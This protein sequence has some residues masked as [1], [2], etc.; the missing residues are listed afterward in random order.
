MG[1]SSVVNLGA[2]QGTMGYQN[3][4]FTNNPGKGAGPGGTCSGDSG[5]PAFWI[6]PAT[7]L[8][9]TVIMAVNSYSITPKCNGTDYQFRT[10]IQDALGFVVPYLNWQP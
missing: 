3:F 10:D 6:D 1:T 7:G 8:E 9:T 5:G 2:A 4:M